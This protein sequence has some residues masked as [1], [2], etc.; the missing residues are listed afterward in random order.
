MDAYSFDRSEHSAARVH[1]IC[2]A[3]RAHQ[4]GRFGHATE[5]LTP[6][7]PVSLP[8]RRLA[9][10]I[11]KLSNH[12]WSVFPTTTPNSNPFLRTLSLLLEERSRNL[13]TLA[14][15]QLCRGF[16]EPQPVC[17]LTSH[18]ANVNVH[19]SLFAPAFR[20]FLFDGAG[21]LQTLHARAVAT[22]SITF[23]IASSIFPLLP[24][25][26]SSVRCLSVGRRQTVC[27]CGDRYGNRWIENGKTGTIRSCFSIQL[28]QYAEGPVCLRCVVFGVGRL[29]QQG[30]NAPTCNSAN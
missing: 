11:T 9:V 13:R 27:S 29:R 16:L 24:G 26:A 14:A 30:T 6:L 7:S 1:S 3:T 8:V 19:R 15:R 22:C 17:F 5:P 20:C 10:S 2:P 28:P 4:R 12:T 21:P 18:F 23:R 25:R